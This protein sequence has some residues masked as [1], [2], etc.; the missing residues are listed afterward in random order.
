MRSVIIG[1]LVGIVAGL[2]DALLI[3]TAP[4]V[5]MI[6]MVGFCLPWALIGAAIGYAAWRRKAKAG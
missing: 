6:E 2:G 3:T 4:P 5:N 1:T